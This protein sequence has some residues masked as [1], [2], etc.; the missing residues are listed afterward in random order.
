MNSEEVLSPSESLTKQKSTNDSAL[1][2]ADFSASDNMHTQLILFNRIS[3]ELRTRD[4]SKT[5]TEKLLK[6]WFELKYRLE[7]SRPVSSCKQK[8]FNELGLQEVFFELPS[9]DC[10]ELSGNLP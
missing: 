2:E 3:E 9:F 10:F 6:M 1:T 8:D 7:N 4:L 5:P